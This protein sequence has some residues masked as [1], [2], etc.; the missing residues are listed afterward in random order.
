MVSVHYDTHTTLH[1]A[2]NPSLI[3][4]SRQTSEVSLLSNYLHCQGPG[5]IQCQCS[6]PIQ[7]WV[8]APPAFVFHIPAPVSYVVSFP[9]IV[10]LVGFN[11]R[12]GP[13]KR[14]PTSIIISNDGKVTSRISLPLSDLTTVPNVCPCTPTRPCLCTSTAHFRYVTSSSH[15]HV[16]CWSQ[17]MTSPARAVM[18]AESCTAGLLLFSADPVC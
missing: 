9:L 14:T 8:L 5:G 6:N 10:S 18:T 4:G 1:I 2:A 12:E 3:G 13:P 17:G 15:H 11:A 16:R 7:C